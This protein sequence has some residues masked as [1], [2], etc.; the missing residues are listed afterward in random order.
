[1]CSTAWLTDGAHIYICGDALRMAKD[2]EAALV[3]IIARHGSRTPAEAVRFLGE[4]K[5]A[6]RYQV[7]VY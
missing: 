3:E 6:G 4:L 7:D 1:M 5:A 2:V